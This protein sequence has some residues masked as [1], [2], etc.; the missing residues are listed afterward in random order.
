MLN[1]F[2]G[3]FQDEGLRFGHQCFLSLKCPPPQKK[4]SPHT[5]KPRKTTHEAGLIIRQL[6]TICKKSSITISIN[7][8]KIR[9]TSSMERQALK[10]N[11]SLF[12][13]MCYCKRNVDNKT[14]NN[15]NAPLSWLGMCLQGCNN[16][17]KIVASLQPSRS[18]LILK[19]SFFERTKFQ[20]TQTPVADSFKSGLIHG[21]CRQDQTI[22]KAF[23]SL[24]PQQEPLSLEQSATRRKGFV[25]HIPCLFK[26]L[27][28]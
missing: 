16:R 13:Q 15:N 5:S 17:D 6:Q 4:K 11:W 8:F 26:Q 2:Q 24:D 9:E 25:V 14:N 7:V 23:N 28:K 27:S 20:C 21:C 3:Q 18:V 1:G 22:C 10:M 12:G 19:S